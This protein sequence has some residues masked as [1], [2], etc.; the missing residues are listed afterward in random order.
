MAKQPENLQDRIPSNLADNVFDVLLHEKSRK[1]II[2]IIKEREDNV[3]FSEKVKK[4]AA[5]EMDKRI[6]RSTKYW[7]VVILT[8]ILTA[9][10]SIF[11]GVILPGLFIKK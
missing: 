7:T 1:H 8:A 11:V 2:E 4:Y 10:I 6:F 9:V 5:E 3:E